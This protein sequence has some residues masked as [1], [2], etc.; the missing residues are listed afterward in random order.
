M[1]CVEQRGTADWF[2]DN[3]TVNGSVKQ[4]DTR[5]ATVPEPASLLLFGTGL[6][7]ASRRA[8]ARLS[9]PGTLFR[10]SAAR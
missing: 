8:R 4:L 10:T 3:V 2:V 9:L 7:L 5:D 6:L 1:G